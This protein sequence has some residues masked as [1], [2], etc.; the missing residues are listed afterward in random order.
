MSSRER[1]ASPAARAHHVE[2]AARHGD[3]GR[4]RAARRGGRGRGL[5]CA[6]ERRPLVRRGPAPAPGYRVRRAAG[7]PAHRA[8]G[9]ARRDRASWPPAEPTCSRASALLPEQAVALRTRL[10]AACAGDRA[11]A[12]RARGRRAQRLA[13]AL[14]QLPDPA[15]PEAVELMMELAVGQPVPGG[16]RGDV[17]LGHARRSTAPGR[18][19]TARW[20]PRPPACSRWRRRARERSSEAEAHRATARE[21]V[22]ALPDAQLAPRLAAA[23]YLATAE[24]YLDRFEEAAAHAG[25]GLELARATGQMSPTLVPTLVTAWSMTGRLAEA[26]RLLDGALESAR[27]SGIPQALAWTLVN[28]SIVETAAGGRGRGA[29]VREGE[30]R[31]HRAVRRALHVGMGRARPGPGAAAGRRSG[32]RG[33]GAGPPRR[34]ARS[35]RRSPPA[36]AGSGFEALVRCRLAL[37]ERDAARRSLS[38]PRL[39]AAAT[40]LPM[41]TAWAHRAA[42][43][44]ALDAG[45]HGRGRGACARLGRL[46]GAGGSG[47]R[48]GALAHARRPGAGAGRRR[49]TG[50]LSELERAAEALDACGAPRLRDAAERELRKLGRPCLPAHAQGHHRRRRPGHAHRTRAPSRRARRRPQ[51]EPGDRRRALPQPQ[52]G[53]DTP[54]Q[55]LP[56]ARRVNS[57]SSSHAPSS[58]PAAR[59]EIRSPLD[60]G[61]RRRRPA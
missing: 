31:A 8:R 1:G 48:G 22:D 43:D 42:A 30:P 20:P 19:A 26:S 28:R 25:R 29:L 3:D 9:R 5:T 54:A 53:R 10:T 44:V 18:W 55:H 16:L 12:R 36:G 24:L 2:H 35:S 23:G 61:A 27:A 51:N 50:A 37:G 47:H 39:T 59:P 17:R 33:R 38:S 60:V 21:L 49:A 52:D 41:A 32:T 57:A 7:R 45:E 58:A 56:Q 13:D 34:A 40:G 46:G 6:R 4:A 14:E 11:P 15:T